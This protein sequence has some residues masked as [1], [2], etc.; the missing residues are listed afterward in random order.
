[1]PD[2]RFLD[3]FPIGVLYGIAIVAAL[4][5]VESGYRIG[6][7][8]CRRVPRE[9][10]G[11][12]GAMTAATLALLA[13]LLAFITG[14]AVNRFDA[15]QRLVVEE[16]NA[17][18]TASLRAGYLAEPYRAE[19]RDL[20]REYL[21]QRLLALDR[22]RLAEARQRSE[23]IHVAL[24]TRTEAVARDFPSP[25]TGLFLASINDVID[26]HTARVTAAFHLRLP[27]PFLLGLFFCALLT[28]SM[29]GFHNSLLGG[30]SLIP[31]MALILVFSAV[32]ILIVDLDRSLEGMLRISTHNLESLRDQWSSTTSMQDP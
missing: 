10:E 1:M 17:I 19:V 31:L 5:A 12:S 27:Q 30:R 3:V 23:E 14:V 24:W 4:L 6:I 18:G 20:L 16:A 8:W 7:L 32:M 11:A 9:K 15:R 25:V 29:V 13:F 26:L 21:D 22:S 28:L 2:F